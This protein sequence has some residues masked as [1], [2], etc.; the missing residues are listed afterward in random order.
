MH[1]SFDSWS[2]KALKNYITT[3]SDKPSIYFNSQASKNFNQRIIARMVLISKQKEKKFTN[4]K[5]K[6]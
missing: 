6:E 1:D 4:Q 3:L 5:Q 2:I